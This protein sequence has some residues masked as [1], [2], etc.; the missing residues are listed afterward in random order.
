MITCPTKSGL[1][2]TIVWVGLF[3][4]CFIGSAHSQ[5]CTGSFGDPIVNITFGSG[6]NATGLGP[7]ITS[8]SFVSTDCP[9]DG[10]YTIRSST[11]NCF[12]TWHTITSDHTGDPQGRF[13]LANASF[14]PGDFYVQNVSGLCANTTF[15]FAA[16]VMNVV[17]IPNQIQPNLTFTV[18]KKD[19]TVLGIYQSGNI[20]ITSTP[21]WKKVGFNFKTPPGVSEV[22]LRIKNNAPGG[23]G[24]DI[25]LDDITFRACGPSLTNTLDNSTD[26]IQL[27]NEEAKPFQLRATVPPF[28]L[29]PL[30][31]WQ[32][33]TDQGSSWADIAG[34]NVLELTVEP[35]TVG[36]YWY[37][38]SAAEAENFNTLSCR[39]VS[40]VT[41]V[42]IHANP[43]V[44]AGPDK[45]VIKGE[46][47]IL[48]GA[49]HGENATFTWQ[50]LDHME[51]AGSLNPGVSPGIDM[52]YT[53]SAVSAHGC[54]ASD[55]V[56]VKVINGIYIPTSF[57]PNGDGL[58]DRWRIPNIE[59]VPDAEVRIFNR[60]GNLIYHSRG[61]AASWDGTIKG[62]P[63][64]SG[65]YIYWVR[66][67]KGA[68][69][70]KGFLTLV[71]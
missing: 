23:I 47:V 63:Q 43:V 28:F 50:P 66:L 6:D 57:T 62:V 54:V 56:S 15:E 4:C 12:G 46:L 48:Q 70:I 7:G 44:S 68:A 61:T 51:N 5:L 67:K 14:D 32:V 18:E 64:S 65:V 41:A 19:G 52:T 26:T 33:S 1:F 36:T 55:D 39:V 16:W 27:C 8:Y 20:D 3:I 53:L 13:M 17:R 40:N 58:N 30:Y 71:R 2:A 29:N 25:A 24:N 31:Q 11:S 37:R 42:R 35:K 60:Y 69:P 38:L 34:G 9:N 22:V 10:S 59:Y 45:V 49:L 21:Q